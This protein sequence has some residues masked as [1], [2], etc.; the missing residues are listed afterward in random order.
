ME[1]PSLGGGNNT[2]NSC[3]VK[4]KSTC[5]ILSAQSMGWMNSSQPFPIISIMQELFVGLSSKYIAAGFSVQAVALSAEYQQLLTMN[6]A[7]CF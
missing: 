6:M 5:S 7:F 1:K 3:F 4:L 2:E